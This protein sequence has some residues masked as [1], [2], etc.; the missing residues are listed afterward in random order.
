MNIMKK[1]I[2][3]FFLVLFSSDWANA[4]KRLPEA[5]QRVVDYI[6]KV[7]GTQV[8]TGECSDFIFNAAY[9]AGTEDKKRR[10]KNRK[11]LPGDIITFRNATVQ[12]NAGTVSMYEHY[13]IVWK[14]KEQGVR[15]VARRDKLD[16]GCDKE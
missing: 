13:A 4:Q 9:Y 8:G 12:S 15:A 11:I 1:L 10:K 14:V 3:L 5:N 16:I 7:I 6:A 2:L